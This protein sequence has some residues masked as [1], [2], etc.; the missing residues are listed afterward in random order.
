MNSFP[1][2]ADESELNDTARCIMAAVKELPEKLRKVFVLRNIQ[3]MNYAEISS[4]LNLSIGTVK[5][6]MHRALKKL[7]ETPDLIQPLSPATE[8]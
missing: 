3:E 7:K 8:R 6:R 5:S 1:D 4:I 2:P